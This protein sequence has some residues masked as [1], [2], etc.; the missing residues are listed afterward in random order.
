MIVPELE[1]LPLSAWLVLCLICE[2]PSHGFA[3]VELLAP[4]GSI[5]R[6]WQVP[7]AVVY[8]G[9]HQLEMD[10]LIEAAAAE[11]RT[12]R[13]EPWRTVL[14]EAAHLGLFGRAG[15]QVTSTADAPPPGRAAGR[16]SLLATFEPGQARP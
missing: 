9:L 11:R 16:R 4:A 6:I 10:G 8:R 14:P 1:E 13:A 2:K 5:G 7:K 15:W 3:L 12:G